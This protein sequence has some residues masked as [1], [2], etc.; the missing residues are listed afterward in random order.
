MTPE[1]IAELREYVRADY[2]VQ[3][4]GM[5]QAVSECLD[6]IAAQ[7]R[8][9]DGLYGLLIYE[10]PRTDEP[11]DVVICYWF[12]RECYPSMEAAKAAVRAAWEGK[13]Q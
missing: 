13:C 11:G 9:I 5:G 7:Q 6:T 2:P 3:V 10:R 12:S 4:Y 8:E 1:R